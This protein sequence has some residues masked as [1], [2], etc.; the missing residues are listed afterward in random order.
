MTRA[1]RRSGAGV[2]GSPS[3]ERPRTGIERILDRMRGAAV[4]RRR[5]LAIVRTCEEGLA[6]GLWVALGGHGWRRLG[7]RSPEHLRSYRAPT[8]AEQRASDEGRSSARRSLR[9]RLGDL[10]RGALDVALPPRIV[11]IR[12]A[13]PARTNAGFTIAVPTK[14]LRPRRV[15]MLD[16]RGGRVAR[17]VGRPLSEGYLATRARFS[18]S[19]PTPDLLA[20]GEDWYVESYVRGVA[21]D[22]LD[23]D[24]QVAAIRSVFRDRRHLLASTARFGP[25][26]VDRHGA[27]MIRALPPPAWLEE[28]SHGI[29]PHRLLVD[30]PL[31]PSNQDVGP[32]NL[33]VVDGRVVTIDLDPDALGWSPFYEDIG[34][35]L[36]PKVDVPRRRWFHEGRFDDELAASDAWAGRAPTDPAASRHR[37]LAAVV[38]RRAVHLALHEQDP[39]RLLA[40]LEWD[41]AR[42]GAGRGGSVAP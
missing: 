3:G 19:V 15:V 36:L 12:G 32:H 38:M 24:D 21:L 5:T 42:R 26:P 28:L 18:A 27:G 25:L 7:T 1:D 33:L 35:L 23:E 8:A 17:F 4:V 41:L 9:S 10:G 11:R 2:S 16:A 6:P 37:L 39:D 22:A 40:L 13:V 29:A 31:V 30:A 14:P 20:H 34:A